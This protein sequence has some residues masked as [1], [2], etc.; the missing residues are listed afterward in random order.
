[1]RVKDVA[2]VEREREEMRR[3]FFKERE[4]KATFRQ[5]QMRRT[6]LKEEQERLKAMEE[7]KLMQ[8]RN[9]IRREAA[10]EQRQLAKLQKEHQV[11]PESFSSLSLLSPCLFILRR[12]SIS[13]VNCGATR[14]RCV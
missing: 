2:P 11:C 9:E 6:Q 12:R 8:E 7:K 5:K 14:T 4:R 3:R 10:R 1:M 13:I